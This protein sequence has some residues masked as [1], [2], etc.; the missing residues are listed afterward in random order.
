[1]TSTEHRQRFTSQCLIDK[2]WQHH[3][4]SPGLSWTG[5]VKQTSDDH[6]QPSRFVIG[7]GEELVDGL[8]T[9]IAPAAFGGRAIY[10]VVIFAERILRALSIYLR[11]GRQYA[12]VTETR[13]LAQHIVGAEDI[14]LNGIYRRFDDLLHADRRGE[15]KN[16]IGSADQRAQ[17]RDVEN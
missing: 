2:T 16:N 3:P 1:M 15:M 4:V 13:G 9:S 5:R 17:G 8:G 7:K 14:G 10:R 11:S 6:G 12:Q